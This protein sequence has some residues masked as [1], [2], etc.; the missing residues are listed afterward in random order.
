MIQRNISKDSNCQR[1]ET[2][3]RLI[4]SEEDSAEEESIIRRASVIERS[5]ASR[6]TTMET[7]YA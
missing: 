4:I 5:F 6:R 3:S 1:E 2:S 7:I